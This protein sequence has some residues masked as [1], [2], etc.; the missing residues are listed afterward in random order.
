MSMF[1][2]SAL[3]GR[4]C[5]GSRAGGGWLFPTLSVVPQ[6]GGGTSPRTGPPPLPPV[7]AAEGFSIRNWWRNG[8]A[9]LVTVIFALLILANLFQPWTPDYRGSGYS[10]TH[11]EGNE[12]VRREYRGVNAKGTENAFVVGKAWLPLAGVAA[13]LYACGRPRKPL[14]GLRWL[15]AAA[16]VCIAITVGNHFVQQQ[17]AQEEWL[18]RFSSRPAVTPPAAVNWVILFSLGAAVSGA[19]FA[20]GA[21]RAAPQPPPLPQ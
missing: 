16:A 8:I 9:C 18:K 13:I 2:R 5:P 12:R 17:Q 4:K 7:P 15:P 3:L 20:R 6:G 11:W 1:Y 10:E 14:G 21:S 19:V